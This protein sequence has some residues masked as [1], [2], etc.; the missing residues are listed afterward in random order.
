GVLEVSLHQEAGL[1]LADDDLPCLVHGGDTAI[2]GEDLHLEVGNGTADRPDAPLEIDGGEA[3]GFGHSVRFMDAH[4]EAPLERLPEV[5]RRPAAPCDAYRMVAIVRPRRLLEQETEHAAEIVHAC[6]AMASR[7]VPE[8]R[9]AEPLEQGH[10]H[11]ALKAGD[12]HLATADVI[13]R[14]PGQHDVAR[15]DLGELTRDIS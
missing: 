7:V 3:G 1:A 15:T 12:D 9:G 8:R 11:A 4:A 13:E 2:L 14:L 5:R 6:R 10:R